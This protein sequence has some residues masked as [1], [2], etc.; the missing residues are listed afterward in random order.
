[1]TSSD[2]TANGSSTDLTTRFPWLQGL[3]EDYHHVFVE[4]WSPY[5]GAIVL[6]VL[7]A[8]LMVNGLFWG[9]FGGLKLW[10]DYLNS[11]LG[12]G[13]ALGIANELESPLL[14]RT[15]LMNI[16]LLCGAFSAALMA[17]QFRVNRPP[18]QEYIWAVVGGTL[19]GF[20]ASL[21]GGCTIGG[22]FT[23]LMFSSAAG[24]AMWLGLL[25]GALLGLKLLLWTMEHFTWGTQAPARS[26]VSRLRRVF[27]WIGF[28][29]LAAVLIWS[30]AWFAETDKQLA[31]RA[32]IVI[33]GFALGFTL[34]RSR[35]CFARVFREPFMTAEGT[36]TKAM[37]LA[38][39]LGIPV[40]SVLL[41]QKTVDPYLAI[42]A[43]FWLGS[44]IGGVIFGIG[45]VFAGGCATGSMWRA[46]EGHLKL[47]VAAFFFAWTGSIFSGVLKQLGFSKTDV[48]I[49]FLDGI[50]EIS[51]LGYQAYLPDLLH[52]WGWAFLLSFGLL[53]V[54][55]LLVRYNENTERFTVL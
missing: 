52:D 25:L 13:T 15:S 54:W 4:P 49:D 46:A 38:I 8:I 14:H 11:W 1:M 3:R 20:G 42:P 19:M 10:G 9:V 39:A 33:T 37:M 30:G 26:S 45:M 47:V 41:H 6:V 21:A 28:A 53:T 27:P 34:H 51:S 24:W 40:G 35:F 31:N 7:F 48:D 2:T 43:S 22:F 36:M 12:L 29:V 17:R 44:L 23:P 32:I 5:L 18:L 16:V 50:P 55:Y